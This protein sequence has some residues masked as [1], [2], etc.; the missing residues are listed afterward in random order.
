MTRVAL[1]SD[2]HANLDAFQS[3]LQHIDSVGA[4]MI[5][6]LGDIVG[7]GPAPSE[8]IALVREREIPTVLGNHDEY[9]TLIDDPHVNALRPEIKQVVE[10]TQAHLSMDDLMWL[11]KL[12]KVI[13]AEAF[14]MVHSSFY[15]K[16]RWAYCVDEKT[17]QANFEYQTFQLAFC[18]HSHQ[19]LMAFEQAGALPYVDNIRATNLP[20]EGKIIVNVGSVGQPRDRDPR[21]CVV[22]YEV[23]TRKIWMD[24]VE[25]DLKAAYKRFMQAKLPPRFADRIM[26]GK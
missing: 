18:G 13:D 22:F 8:C 11:A 9:V 2:I 26:F 20:E 16:S 1:I 6:C 14:G 23:E 3:A 4:D 25:Y 21:S 7:Y 12:P 19:P 15:G 5:L 24:R 17:I 10:W